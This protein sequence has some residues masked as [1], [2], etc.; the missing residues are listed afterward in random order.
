[1][2]AVNGDTLGLAWVSGPSGARFIQFAG[3]SKDGA[4]EVAPPQVAAE[5]ASLPTSIHS[6]SSGWAVVYGTSVDEAMCKVWVL[7]LAANGV[8]VSPAHELFDGSTTAVF[9][10]A[11]WDGEALAVV[12]QENSTGDVVFSLAGLDGAATVPATVGLTEEGGL[13]PNVFWVGDR[14]TITWQDGSSETG[15]IQRLATSAAC[16]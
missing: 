6:T 2:V 7:H 8:P 10:R 16:E 5:G 15:Y 13:L 3:L 12:W 14:Y 9:P 1:V 4:T 11:A